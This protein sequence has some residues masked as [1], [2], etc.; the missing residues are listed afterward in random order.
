MARRIFDAAC[1]MRTVTEVARDWDVSWPSIPGFLVWVRSSRR[2]VTTMMAMP[3][4]VRRASA[5]PIALQAEMTAS[6]LLLAPGDW[7]QDSA[8][9]GLVLDD[10]SVR[11]EVGADRALQ[12]E[13]ELRPG[14][15]VGQP[16]AAPRRRRAA[17][18]DPPVDVVKHDLD[19]PRAAAAS[20]G[21]RD[22][23]HPAFRQGT[24]HPLFQFRPLETLSHAN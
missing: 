2:P 11:R 4:I 24:F 8:P 22:V 20:A 5:L 15:E 16:V 17:D 21:G 6:A 10:T 1:W 23:C 12:V 3:G 9:F 7:C 13:R 18:V 14:V 19:P